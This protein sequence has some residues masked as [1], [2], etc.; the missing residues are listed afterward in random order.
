MGA[1]AAAG[2]AVDNPPAGARF[3]LAEV[4][5]LA[6]FYAEESVRR[7][8]LP[9]GARLAL[10]GPSKQEKIAKIRESP[11]K[12][13]AAGVVYPFG[14]S[15]PLSF[16]FDPGAG[17]LTVWERMIK[18]RGSVGLWG[19]T[20]PE[21]ATALNAASNARERG[22]ADFAWDPVRDAL[23]F[24]LVYRTVPT[25][26][27]RFYR[28]VDRLL[29]TQRRWS[30][31]PFLRAMTKLVEERATP[32]SATAT[33]DGFR[34]TVALRHF[35][36]GPEDTGTWVWRYVQAWNREPPRQAPRLV[37]DASFRFGQP[38]HAFVH[39][40]DAAADPQGAARVTA[41]LDIF[42]P[43]GAR[44][45]EPIEIDVFHG[46]APPRGFL[47]FG[48]EGATVALG[49]DQSPGRYDFRMRV[50]DRVADRCVDLVHPIELVG[51]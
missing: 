47:Q 51:R 34:A 20:A 6:L 12:A 7:L 33:I 19:L 31:G 45:G 26:R 36:A 9:L 29:D 24:R 46:A 39:F 23:S 37:S 41:V 11:P 2:A 32:P 16:A 14:D 28:E 18:K 4:E 30:D 10:G 22:G 44:H 21:T 43:D 5:A 50:C 48:D 8:H 13:D 17:T 49:D 1:A 35:A 15:N 42:G 27:D 25:D 38:L 3:G 40:A